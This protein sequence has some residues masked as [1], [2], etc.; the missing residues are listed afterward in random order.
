MTDTLNAEEKLVSD[1]IETL[2]TEH[3]P[4]AVSA[5]EFLGAQYDA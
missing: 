5:V 4:K 1:A 2:L 3:P